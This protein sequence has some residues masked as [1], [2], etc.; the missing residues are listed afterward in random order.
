MDIV[1]RPTILWKGVI[2]WNSILPVTETGS[3]IH[4]KSFRPYLDLKLSHKDLWLTCFSRL[5][6]IIKVPITN[7][8]F[9]T[10]TPPTTEVTQNCYPQKDPLLF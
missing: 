1:L 6:R 10:S 9:K 7:I 4:A 5:E 8:E 3:F 2:N